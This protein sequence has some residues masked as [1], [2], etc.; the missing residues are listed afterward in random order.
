LECISV[1]KACWPKLQHVA[2]WEV[3]GGGGGGGGRRGGGGGG[4][5]RC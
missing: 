4:G 1:I 3:G 5:G 2:L